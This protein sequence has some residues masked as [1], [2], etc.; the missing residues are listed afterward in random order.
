VLAPLEL[1]V[2]P[3]QGAGPPLP[4]FE[5]VLSLFLLPMNEIPSGPEQQLS[6]VLGWWPAFFG[7]FRSPYFSF[8]Y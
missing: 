3:E 5:V 4:E 1:Q 6:S 2:S 7:Y 8:E